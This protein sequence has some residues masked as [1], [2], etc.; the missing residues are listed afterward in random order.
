MLR[1]LDHEGAETFKKCA[2][3]TI[4]E[5]AL[6]GM[7]VIDAFAHGS[8]QFPMMAQRR[9]GS[10]NYLGL[11][12]LFRRDRIAAALDRSSASLSSAWATR[13]IRVALRHRSAYSC[14]TILLHASMHSLKFAVLRSGSHRWLT[15]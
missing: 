4:G 11:F 2:A 14:T 5:F 9:G 13:H 8:E 6:A 15:R 1:F 10:S 3:S 12:A 7:S